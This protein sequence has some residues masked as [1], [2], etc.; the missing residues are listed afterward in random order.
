MI[1]LEDVMRYREMGLLFGI[2]IFIISIVLF[3]TKN[4]SK[5]V[6]SL[7]LLF[8]IAIV[9]LIGGFKTILS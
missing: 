5:I 2:V 1:N 4:S 3:N 6:Q 7:P 8:F 9:L